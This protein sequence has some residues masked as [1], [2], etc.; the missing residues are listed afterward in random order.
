MELFYTIACVETKLQMHQ[1]HLI[2]NHRDP[3]M[4]SKLHVPSEAL[5][6]FELLSKVR[7]EEDKQDNVRIKS[8][9]VHHLGCAKQ[10]LTRKRAASLVR[11]RE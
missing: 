5:S 3:V 8:K 11:N 4:S 1:T 7:P 9:G 2:C 10:T 6:I